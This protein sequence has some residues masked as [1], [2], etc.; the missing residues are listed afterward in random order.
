M[1]CKFTLVLILGC[2]LQICTNFKAHTR[3][4]FVQG[5]QTKQLTTNNLFAWTVAS[6]NMWSQYSCQH[7]GTT[8]PI[9]MPN[10]QSQYHLNM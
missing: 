4:Q 2:P 5:E 10:M 3:Q 8:C 9:V 6:T 1:D 7:A